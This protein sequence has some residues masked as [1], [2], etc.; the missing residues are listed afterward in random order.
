VTDQPAGRGW[1]DRD[2]VE[3]IEAHPLAFVISG[4][5][6]VTTPLPMLVETDAS[7]RP[8]TL[9]GH[10]ARRNPHVNVLRA[11]PRGC[12]LFVGPHGY[13]S[14]ELV[15][16]TK[17]WA[18]TWNYAFARVVADVAFDEELNGEAIQRLVEKMERGRREPWT[19]AEMGARYERL[20]AQVI[21]FRATI[22]DV[23][24]RFKLGQ[25][26]RPEVL[27]DI[28]AGFTGTGLASWMQRFN[29]D[30]LTT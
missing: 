28:V 19:T 10:F 7:G 13:V 25:D 11:D 14:P 1:T 17:D 26:E 6:F 4:E 5:G 20:K 18:P 2:V 16:T 27:E 9:L 3:L 29:A 12:F 24:A 23:A 21:G 8:A 15:T 30:R 22:V